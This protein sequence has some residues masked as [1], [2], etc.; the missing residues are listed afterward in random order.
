MALTICNLR[1]S[2]NFR[3]ADKKLETEKFTKWQGNIRLSVLNGKRG[4][5]PEVISERIFRKITVHSFQ[6]T[7]LTLRSLVLGRVEKSKPSTLPR[8]RL[9]SV[10]LVPKILPR[11]HKALEYVCFCWIFDYLH[12][13]TIEMKC[14][15]STDL[16]SSFWVNKEHGKLASALSF[17]CFEDARIWVT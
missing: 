6:G 8:T 16:L 3:P 12:F 2:R 14:A 15:I 1:I 9:R 4:L 11:T 17:S 10:R 7:S 5:S 13:L